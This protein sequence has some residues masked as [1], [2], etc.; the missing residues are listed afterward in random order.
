MSR[1]R[2]IQQ[3]GLYAAG[4]SVF[5]ESILKDL[6]RR[7]NSISPNDK[8]QVGL[9]G[10]KGMG[11]SDLSSMLKIPEIECVALCDIDKNVIDSRIKDLTDK[12]LKKPK[13][14]GDYRKMLED[15]DIDVVIIGTPDHW[16]CL[17]LAD[18]LDAGKDVYCEKPIANS[19]Q[20]CDIMLTK[21]DKSDRIVQIGQWQRSQKHF[22]DAIEYVRSG[23]LGDIRVSKVWS[24]QGWMNSVPVVPDSP[25]PQGVDYDMW[26]GPA[27]KR[28][29]NKN[30]FHFNFR[31]FWDYAGGLMTDWGVHL[32]D[33]GIY[34][35]DVVYPESVMA[36]GGKYG[37]PDSAEETPDTMQAVYDYGNFSLIWEHGTGINS[38]NFGMN[39]GIGFIGN[40][41]TLALNRG[42]WKVIPEQENGKDKIEAI[43]WMPSV[44]NGLDLNTQNFIDVVKSRN[45]SDL[46]TPL[47]VGYNAAVVCHLGNIA[48]KAGEKVHWDPGKGKFAEKNANK[49]LEAEYHNNWKLPKV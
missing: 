14:Y 6:L 30:R 29:F 11:F 10:C 13:T 18:T 12:G 36:V 23:K 38:G 31:W 2:F 1:R 22:N 43:E 44:D 37:Y 7:K 39:H 25:V 8:I 19:I 40:N 26:L 35:M 15:K 20:E 3:S 21:A 5:P 34:G 48:L 32:M 47:Q 4:I 46:N 17:Q 42:G 49:F 45:K 33:Y 16:H 24:Y 28:P 27:P 9:I 41:G